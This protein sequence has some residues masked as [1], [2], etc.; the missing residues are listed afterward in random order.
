MRRLRSAN[1]ALPATAGDADA[2]NEREKDAA[3][4]RARLSELAEMICS[5]LLEETR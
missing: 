2:S 3:G 4:I 5:Y 1:R